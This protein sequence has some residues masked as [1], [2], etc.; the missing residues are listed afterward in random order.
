MCMDTHTCNSSK[1]GQRE[2][3]DAPHVCETRGGEGCCD[4]WCLMHSK[5]AFLMH[6]HQ[7][8]HA[9]V[10]HREPSCTP[11]ASH[12]LCHATPHFATSCG[13]QLLPPSPVLLSAAP[14]CLPLAACCCLPAVCCCAASLALPP[15]A[16][17]PLT[18][19]VGLVAGLAQ[20]ALQGAHV[21]PGG[22]QE[23]HRLQQQEGSR[24]AEG[25]GRGGRGEGQR[26]GQ[27]GRG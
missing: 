17:L 11:W 13:C 22:T 15:A 9:G 24:G 20:L 2:A 8:H 1:K 23:A 26:G 25:E 27:K 6:T 18:Q 10:T 5:G 7:Q 14:C 3:S 19:V 12:S 16:L 4:C 21:V